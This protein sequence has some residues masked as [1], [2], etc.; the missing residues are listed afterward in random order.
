MK[1]VVIIL[2][3]EDMR[4]LSAILRWNGT[5]MRLDKDSDDIEI[6]QIQDE[7]GKVR[8]VGYACGLDSRNNKIKKILLSDGEAEVLVW[9]EKTHGLVKADVKPKNGVLD[10]RNLITEA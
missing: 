9:D 8:S 6:V 7:G 2:D 1:S 10:L 5:C 3:E 4:K